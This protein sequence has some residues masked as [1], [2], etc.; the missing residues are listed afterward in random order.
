MDRL[1]TLA[2]STLLYGIAIAMKFTA[3]RHPAFRERLKEQD[4]IGQIRV[5]AGPGRYYVIKNG[6]V[7]SRSGIHPNPDVVVTVKSARLGL[8]IFTHPNDQ[9]GRINAAKSFS[10]TLD[11]PQ[12]KAIWFMFTLESMM[13]AG[14]RYGVDAGNGETRYVNMANGGPLFVYVKDDK[15]I[16]MTPIDFDDRDPQPW[17]IKAKGKE[18]TP[19][20]R[21][22][23]APHG[24]TVKSTIYSPDR[25]LYPMKR[26]DF[27]PN[28]ERNPQN[29]GVSG[30]E[31][32]SWDEALDIVA[33]E[34]KRQKT[35]HGNGAIACSHP[36]HHAWGNIGYYLSALRKFENAVGMTEVHHNPDSWE[37]WYWGATHHWG[38]SMRVGQ[39][40][41]YGTVED[42]LKEA[43]M[44]VFWSSNPESTAART[45]RSRARSAGSGSRKP[46]SSS[47]TSTRTTTTRFSCFG[48]KW[49]APRPDVEPGARARDRVRLDHRRHLRQAVR[50]DAHARLR[51]MA[52]LRARQDGRNPEVARVAGSRDLRARE[53]RSRARA[54]VGAQ[55]DL[56]RRGRLGQRPRRRMPE[57]DRHSVGAHD[58]V[59]HRDAG[60]RQARRQHG[61]PPV[62][63]AARLQL[64]FPGLR[65]RRHVG[66]LQPHRD[67]RDALPAYA[68]VAVDQHEHADHPADA[69]A[70]SDH[71][72]A[73][74]KGISG[75]ARAS[76]RSSRRLPT[77]SPGSRPCTCSGSTAARWSRRCPTAT[78]TSTCSGTR[79]S[80]SS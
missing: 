7:S 35:V 76:R 36:S 60:A 6:K 23:L 1:Y 59:P 21:T 44:V 11:G 32:I 73:R 74:R 26:V 28:G 12:D 8:Q 27:D 10:M 57:R 41:T 55:E 66:R 18:F 20:R 15:I 14:W 4:V 79:I 19:P 70:R 40:E 34:I 25:I 38:G 33:S 50:R 71:G 43:E 47:S 80:S 64:L 54:R 16:R 49:I 62:G 61:Q 68:A 58:G 30:Y 22:S 72:R 29:R 13:Q 51:Q 78:A 45:A 48:G 42:C 46:A 67:G 63:H 2:F 24:Q 39:S 65:R 17:T 69:A 5:K 77:R 37:G 3:W 31:R 53:R 9:L 75:T 52:R 56:S